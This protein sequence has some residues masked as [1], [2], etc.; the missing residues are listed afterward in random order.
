MAKNKKLKK[1]TKLRRIDPT[2]IEPEEP[3][4]PPPQPPQSP[5]QLKQPRGW[6]KA[7]YTKK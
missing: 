4:P 2:L 7:R 5:Q 6:G 1:S 3:G